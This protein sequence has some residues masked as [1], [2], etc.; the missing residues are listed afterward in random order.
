MMTDTLAIA[1]C[2]RRIA[3]NT[4]EGTKYVCK[5]LYTLEEALTVPGCTVTRSVTPEICARCQGIVPEKKRRKKRRE[6]S[7]Q[8]EIV[9]ETS[10]K[11]R[12]PKTYV[13]CC[14]GKPVARK[15]E[16]RAHPNL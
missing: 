4:R 3:Y 1:N 13:P 14:G 2:S 12:E 6:K 8:I 10:P 15:Q 7:D 9:I 11:A 5:P 16:R